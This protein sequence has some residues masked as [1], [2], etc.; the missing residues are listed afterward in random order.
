MYC[1][2]RFAVP[3]GLTLDPL[4][5]VQGPVSDPSNPISSRSNPYRSHPSPP[6]NALS[7][8]F[9]FWSP[10]FRGDLCHFSGFS[11]LG[12]PLVTG[13]RST[14]PGFPPQVLVRLWGGA[15]IFS[16]FRVQ[17]VAW[18]AVGSSEEGHP[19]PPAAAAG[20]RQPPSFPRRAAMP[21]Q[22][23]SRQEA[24]G[25]APPTAAKGFAALRQLCCATRSLSL[26]LVMP[27][28]DRASPRSV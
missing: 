16:P 10:L 1:F 11:A 5:A 17:P 6:P 19:Y 20:Y 22:T 23:S 26:S 27:G 2:S 21:L 18:Q 12:T 28:C 4:Q 13:T 25:G 7:R 9:C 14:F 8:L 24:P 15:C 3:S